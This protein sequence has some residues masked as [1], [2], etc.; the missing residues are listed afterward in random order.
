[1]TMYMQCHQSNSTLAYICCAWPQCRAK[2]ATPWIG[3][4]IEQ[5]W[6]NP[7]PRLNFNPLATET[8]LLHAQETRE[9]VEAKLQSLPW[10]QGSS[11]LSYDRVIRMML[12][13]E[14]TGYLFRSAMRRFFRV[15]PEALPSLAEQ[16]SRCLRRAWSEAR[17]PFCTS[18]V[19]ACLYLAQAGML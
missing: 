14:K 19:D 18:L 2:F 1:M 10:V 7:L 13:L 16:S 4:C 5:R 3:R 6:E 9:A 11:S 12:E 17:Y 8:A 15:L